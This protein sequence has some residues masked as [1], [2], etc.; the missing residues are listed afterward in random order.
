MF[1]NLVIG[2]MNYLINQSFFVD[3]TSFTF[4]VTAF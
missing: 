1:R 2:R 3:F 4:K